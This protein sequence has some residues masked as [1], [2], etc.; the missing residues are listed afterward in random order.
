MSYTTWAGVGVRGGERV[1]FNISATFCRIWTIQLAP[2]SLLVTLTTYYQKYH[3]IFAQM[4]ANGV[5]LVH[6][7]S[8][9]AL[10]EGQKIHQCGRLSAFAAK[11]A[12]ID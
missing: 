4:R 7:R 8:S 2:S 12:L 9:A 1:F 11:R 6:M 10:Q 5:D 3:L